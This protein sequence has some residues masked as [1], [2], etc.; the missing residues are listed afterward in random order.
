MIEIDGAMGEGGGQVLRS[1]LSLSLATNQEFKIANIRL[2]RKKP[3][4][5]PQH[6]TSVEI[7]AK[8]SQAD[9]EGAELNSTSLFFSP[10]TIKPG[11]YRCHIGTAGATSLVLQTI[12]LPLFFSD[13]ASNLTISGGT[14][15]PIA[16]SFDFL[17]LHW[18]HYLGLLGLPVTLELEQA[19]FFPQGGGIIHA[20]INPAKT[21][22]PLILVER[23]PL[24]QIRGLSAV[25]NLDRRIAERQREQVIRRL[26]H[27]YSLNDIRIV[28]LPS[29][30]KGTTIILVCDFENA[31]SCYFSLG[32][33]GKPAEKVADEVCDQIEA[34][35][36][37]RASLDEYIS[38]QL[39]LPLSF[40]KS[41]STLS[42]TKV[43]NHLLTNAEVIQA[44]LPTKI[45][46]SG[47]I[48]SPGTITITP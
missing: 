1:C 19:G 47:K 23:G 44:F 13:K 8:I 18:A 2:R 29:K 11:N 20:T 36:I 45:N 33:L 43:T 30:F 22:S 35:I 39:L 24:N 27:K 16:P 32:A 25:A 42:T 5:R 41:Q 10:K 31:Q 12:Y 17:K 4:L 48:G 21:I 40:A 3:G 26:G 9:I 14:H 37:S 46:I 15:A 6:L 7:A 38:D 34:H 28:Q